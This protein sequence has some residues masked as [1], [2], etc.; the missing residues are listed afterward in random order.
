MKTLQ[1][2]LEKSRNNEENLKET[3]HE[4]LCI[5]DDLARDIIDLKVGHEFTVRQL[6]MQLQA[7]KIRNASLEAK[8][9]NVQ[10]TLKRT[11]DYYS[12]IDIL[13]SYVVI[14]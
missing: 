7:Q 1:D 9:E 12:W 13:K 6:T 11:K 4:L 14:A 3:R 5:Q 2:E 8:L 10:R